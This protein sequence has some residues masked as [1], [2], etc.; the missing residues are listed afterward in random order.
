[1]SKEKTKFTIKEDG[2][3]GELFKSEN[4]ICPNKA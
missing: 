3:C 1:M 4:E 2:F